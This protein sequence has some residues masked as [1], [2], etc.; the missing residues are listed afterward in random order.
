MFWLLRATIDHLTLQSNLHC[1]V[2]S[3]SHYHYNN[4]KM[5][6][7]YY[8]FYVCFAFKIEFTVVPLVEDNWGL[9]SILL[10]S[11]LPFAIDLVWFLGTKRSVWVYF[12]YQLCCHSAS[13]LVSDEFMEQLLVGIMVIEKFW[14]NHV[15]NFTT[16]RYLANGEVSNFSDNEI[17]RHRQNPDSSADF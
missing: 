12:S 11:W 4:P 5:K 17:V 1:I 14:G 3:I 7:D 9:E 16:S 15:F 2:I 10:F 8:P 13:H 6:Q